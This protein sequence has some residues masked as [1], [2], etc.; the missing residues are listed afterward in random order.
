LKGK[1]DKKCDLWSLG[2]TIYILL[3]GK[4]PFNGDS[5][6]KVYEKILR[7]ECNWDVREFEALS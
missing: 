5:N 3:S 4:P 2:V 6:V 7:G 1:Y